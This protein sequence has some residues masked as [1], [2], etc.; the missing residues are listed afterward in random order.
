MEDGVSGHYIDEKLNSVVS[1]RPNRF[2]FEVILQDESPLERSIPA[3]YLGGRDLFL[4]RA[5]EQ[6]APFIHLAKNSQSVK[7]SI[8]FGAGL[9][10]CSARLANL[11][12]L[13]TEI[14][15]KATLQALPPLVTLRNQG[16]CL[17][18]MF[19]LAD[20]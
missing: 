6:D 7:R 19:G 13:L 5:V 12:L 18:S 4:R 14:K 2:A 16:I 15:T 3:Q 17:D 8:V 1:S 10:T 11:K 9:N 20:P